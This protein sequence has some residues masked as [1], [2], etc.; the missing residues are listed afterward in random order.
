MQLKYFISIIFVSTNIYL[1][2]QNEFA[3]KKDSTSVD[4]ETFILDQLNAIN[5]LWYAK[6]AQYHETSQPPLSCKDISTTNIDSIYYLRLKTLTDQTLFPLVYNNHIRSYIDLYTRRY[7]NL[8]LLL[9]VS[10]YY[11]PMFEEALDRYNCPLELKYLAVIESALNP[12]AV[13]RA[14]ATGLWQFMYPTGKMYDLNVSTW[15]DDRRDPLKSTEAAAQHLRDLSEMFWGDWVLAIAAYNCGPGN[16][17]KAIQRS[18]G[19]TDFWDIYNY[20]PRE[21]R[22]Y[23]PAFYGAMYAMKYYD[24]HGILPADVSIDITDTVHVTNKVH[25]QQIAAVIN[26]PVEKLT[27]YNPQYKRNIIPAPSESMVLT[28]PV[29][30]ISLFLANK[31]SIYNYNTNVYFPTRNISEATFASAEQSSLSTKCK[32]HTVKSGESLSI[33]ARR[34]GISVTELSRMNNKRST[35]IHPGEKLIVGHI[36]MP[37]EKKTPVQ[38]QT[39]AKDTPLIVQ[40]LID[41]TIKSTKDTLTVKV[42]NDE[43]N[44]TESSKYID[45]KVQEGD[46]LWSISQRF[47]S[48][49]VDDIRKVN[50]MGTNDRLTVGKTLRIPK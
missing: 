26:I 9:G 15:I 8:S 6:K 41:T 16:V 17:T 24:Q 7:K 1:T 3:V 37:I 20:L 10:K 11:F 14:G 42:L 31:D 27:T 18:G 40:T 34:Y 43:S 39:L 36:K 48:V 12:T 32:Y 44:K 45:Y 28:L 25:F 5:E 29:E 19:K 23:V 21:T 33:I 30:Y 4:E 22:G 35:M 38:N 47:Q 46:T 50:N 49:S 13:S 2:A